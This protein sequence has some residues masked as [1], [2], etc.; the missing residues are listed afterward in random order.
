VRRAWTE[1]CLS[2]FKKLQ[3]STQQNSQLP[4][5]KKNQDISRKKFKLDLS[6]NLALQKIL[7]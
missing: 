7:E 4:Y 5:R 3:I 1:R 2:D 6:I